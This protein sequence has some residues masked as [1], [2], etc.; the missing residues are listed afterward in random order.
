[1][2]P[3]LQIFLIA[4]SCAATFCSGL[5]LWNFRQLS[6]RIAKVEDNHKAIIKQFGDCK[7]D[8]N[9]NF[10]SKEDWLREAGYSRDQLDKLNQ[11][12]NRIDGKMLVMEKLPEICGTIARE[13]SKQ[14]KPSGDPS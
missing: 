14:I 8:C 4:V 7:T 9:R 12:L 5:V 11:T 1:M 13:I 3:I 2:N 10:V 6:G